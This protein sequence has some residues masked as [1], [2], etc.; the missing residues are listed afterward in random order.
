VVDVSP[1]DNTQ[2]KSNSGFLASLVVP[3]GQFLTTY[4]WASRVPAHYD[5]HARPE[6]AIPW[7]RF[8]A[9]ASAAVVIAVFICNVVT[10]QLDAGAPFMSGTTRGVDD[11]IS[12][13]FESASQ[14]YLPR[15]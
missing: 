13:I 1:Y 7:L 8:L 2:S 15:R 11:Q 12:A 5:G 10:V 6:D 9:I 3:I 4:R 14:R